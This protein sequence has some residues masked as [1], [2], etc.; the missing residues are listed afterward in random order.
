M[1]PVGYISLTLTF[2]NQF[3]LTA[4][5]F[6]RILTEHDYSLADCLTRNSWFK[7]KKKLQ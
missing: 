4:V 5:F 6:A 2:L 1:I 3:S 7:K